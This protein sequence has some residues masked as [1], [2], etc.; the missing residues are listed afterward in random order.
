MT[1]GRGAAG[2]AALVVVAAVVI[3]TW[4]LFLTPATLVSGHW[5]SLFGIWRLAW[6]A[7]AMRSS[8]LRLFDAPIFHPHP[9]TLAFSDA[10]LLPGLAFAPLRYAGASPAL[11]YNAALL[12]G[13]V[14]SGLAMFLLVRSL[15]GRAD[16]AAIAAVIYTVA[17]YRLDH[18][19]HFEMQMAAGMP[20]VLWLWHRAI[21]RESVRLAAAAVGGAVLQWLS[22]I[23][24][25]LLFAPV[26]A[27]MAAIEWAGVV[28][29]QRTRLLD[30][31]LASA[32][33]GA[34]VVGVSSI[35]YVTNRSSTGDR[36]PEAVARYS[37]TPASYLA[38]PPHNWLYGSWLAKYGE[39]ETRL[40]PGA[41]ALVLAVA[42]LAAGPWNR[43][44]WAYVAGG[45]VAV[46]L[47]FGTNGLLF[48]ILRDW[49]VP[50]RG[51][52]APARAGVLVL[53]VIS[54]FAGS[55]AAWLFAR[56]PSR[57]A[58]RL[59]AAIIVLVLLVEYRTRPDLWDAPSQAGPPELGITRGAVMVEM[60]MAPPDRLDRSVD[61]YYMV[62]RIGE[63]PRLVNG[64]SGFYPGDYLTFLD[65]T[66]AFPDERAI[67]EMARVG[68]TIV[69]VH[70][71]W[72][73]PRFAEI[74][75]ALDSRTDVERIG[76]YDDRGR[77]VA[78]YQV[79]QR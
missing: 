57:G 38:V 28:K 7:D 74:L 61:A 1:P 5:D 67:R 6:I 21:D 27:V 56:V 12:A 13:F 72:Y 59:T 42:G 34:I 71:R 4:P 41:M 53:L 8:D 45:L 15:A 11:A 79:L 25:G 32:V 46:D 14:T 18:L 48:S 35:P 33:A 64:H 50:Y 16:A 65:R 17:P 31:L 68:V 10:V 37:A 23:Y 54:V 19:D 40:F 62:T 24:Y 70:D 58:A 60:P 36:P 75:A 63:W 30:A 66:R 78:L 77:P 2:A 47:S 76:E 73:G 51:L 52:R 20:L 43:R 69:A 49:A 55:G 9:R 3:V 26:F 29:A 39:A 22:C 44:R